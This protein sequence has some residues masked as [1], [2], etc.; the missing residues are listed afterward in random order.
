MKLRTKAKYTDAV[1]PLELANGALSQRAAEEAIV[2]LENKGIL[3]LKPGKI[4]LYGAG[5]GKT[6]KGGTGSGEVMERRPVSIWEGLE[7]RGFEVVTRS[8]LRDY[9]DLWNREQEAFLQT[10]QKKLTSFSTKVLAELMAAEC[11]YPYGQA[12][13][14]E[15][16]STET[17]TCLYVLSRQ[18]GEGRDRRREDFVLSDT[19]R[20]HLQACS[21]GYRHIV[22]VLNTGASFDLSFVRD[23]P[24]IEAVVYAC[25]LGQAGGYALADVL[26]GAVSPSGK[27]A[28]T[29]VKSY[30]DVPFGEAYGAMGDLQHAAY[31][32]GIY[33]GYRYYD[34]FHVEPAYPFGYGLSYTKFH[35]EPG[36]VQAHGS[37]ITAQVSVKNTGD[38]A[39]RETVQLYVSPPVGKLDREYQSLAAFSKTELLQPGEAQEL[40]LA[41]DMSQLAAYEEETA[42]MVLEAGDYLLRLGNSSRN[43]AVQAVI[44]LEE[45]VVVSQHKNL[46]ASKEK[47]QSLCRRQ[48]C[49]PV[50][51]P[52]LLL[53]GADFIPEITDYTPK[54]LKETGRAS[55]FLDTLSKGAA[56]V[57]RRNRTFR[58]QDLLYPPRGCGQHHLRLLEAGHSQRRLL[59]RTC[60]TSPAAPLHGQ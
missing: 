20:A 44:R 7:S 46:C 57:L 16:L 40:E 37:S 38:W 8:W 49:A 2:L 28:A 32:E 59:R 60:R 29:W 1:T 17:D 10:M 39:G 34:S 22:L 51:A 31:R 18:S 11:P 19:E 14:G 9:N 36:A 53:H 3:P 4:A 35:M 13:R 55:A 45:K 30:E 23:F 56:A 12:I 42:S 43:T 52:T 27:L 58:G 5:A 26:T 33:V 47:V 41:F 15:D 6:I 54:P 50:Q 24:A 48:G 21:E 25:Q